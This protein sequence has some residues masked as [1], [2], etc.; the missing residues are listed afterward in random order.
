[1]AKYVDV[2]PPQQT[3]RSNRERLAP[4]E[5]PAVLE[6][7]AKRAADVRMNMA[8]LRELRRAKEAQENS[9][10]NLRRQPTGKSKT[11]KAVQ[12]I[13][14]FPRMAVG[15]CRRTSRRHLLKLEQLLEISGI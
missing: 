7:E 3:A 4:H 5:R 2:D 8:R 10:R 15:Q 6:E 11:E 13:I 9:D 1:M 12:V 14:A